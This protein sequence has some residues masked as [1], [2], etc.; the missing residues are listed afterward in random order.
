MTKLA[1]ITGASTGIGSAAAELFLQQGFDVVNVSRRHHK[2]PDVQNF[3]CDLSDETAV[4]VLVKELANMIHLCKEV[5][6]VHNAGYLGNDSAAQPD[7]E[8]LQRS[9]AVNVWGPTRL[10]AALIPQL[11]KGSSV[12]YVGSK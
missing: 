10:N 6:L 1:I 3:A 11:P 12:L 8:I 7:F 5:A 9:L 2:N 4:A